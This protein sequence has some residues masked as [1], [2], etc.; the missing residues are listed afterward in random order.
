MQEEIYYIFEH[1]LKSIQLKVIW[2][3][4][5]KQKY[6]EDETICHNFGIADYFIRHCIISMR[7]AHSLL[8]K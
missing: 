5:K 8:H 1:H 2:F 4:Y 3:T 7:T 6:N